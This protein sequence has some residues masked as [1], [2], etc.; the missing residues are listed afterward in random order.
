MTGQQ[1]QVIGRFEPIGRE[2][3]RPRQPF[4]V[5]TKEPYEWRGQPGWQG[6]IT[7]GAEYSV[8]AEHWQFVPAD[9]WKTEECRACGELLEFC[10]CPDPTDKQAEGQ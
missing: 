9:S 4:D 1:P 7:N 10:A 2:V 6:Q 8:I 5:L 3:G